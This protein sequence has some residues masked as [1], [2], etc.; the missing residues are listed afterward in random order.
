MRSMKSFE[1]ICKRYGIKKNNNHT[2][3]R[4]RIDGE[5][6]I[7]DESVLKRA[8]P[9]LSNPNKPISYSYKESVSLDV[10]ASYDEEGNFLIAC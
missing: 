10:K 3:I 6:K 2:G 9:F 8:F 7:L 4:V 1:K 5:F